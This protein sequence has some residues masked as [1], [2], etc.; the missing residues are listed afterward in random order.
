LLLTPSE[1]ATSGGAAPDWIQLFPQG[2]ELA[3]V[4]GRSF[5]MSDPAAIIARFKASGR[6]LL[7]DFDHRSFYDVDAGGSS[8]A[9]G[10]ISDMEVRDGE[11]WG[12]V[13]WSE[14]AAAKIAARQYRYISPEFQVDEKTGEVISISAAGLVNR[15][16]F[17]MTALARR[18]EEEDA[19]MLKNIAKAL[20]LA[21]DADAATILAA[22]EKGHG[23]LAAALGLD[24]TADQ[25]TILAAVEKAAKG[26]DVASFVPRADYELLKGQ[27]GT[28]QTELAA[29]KD[30]NRKA[31]ISAAIDGAVKAGKIAPASRDHYAALCAK[32]GGLEAFKD[33]VGTLP[34]IGAPSDLDGKDVPDSGG[35]IDATALAAEARAYRDEKLGKGIS[36]TTADAVAAV[37]EKR[38]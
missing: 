22:I 25:A 16:A 27:L 4:D 10:W 31:E 28:M 1:L 17:A 5:K 29:I 30:G 20:G 24:K 37:K 19:P 8:E 36:I 23:K 34:V 6:P 18:R 14:A 21:D 35:E 3:A 32:D 7:V 11:I 9:A 13:E 12:R 38:K 26:P 33:L 2:P 15:P